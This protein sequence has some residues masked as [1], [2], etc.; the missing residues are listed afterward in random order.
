MI[1]ICCSIIILHCDLFRSSFCDHA[2]FPCNHTN[3]GVYSS[4]RFHTGTN[5]RS[6]CDHQRHCLTLHVGSH[7]RAVRIVV[8]Q[9]RNQCGSHGEHH[10]RR[11][12]HVI[13]HP[14]LIF[15]C[16]IQITSRYIFMN[17]MTFFIQRLIRLRY[18][19]IVFF[20]R[21]HV[22]Y[23]IR[24]SRILRITLVDPAIRSLYKTIFINSCI[25]CKRVDQTDVWS[26]RRLNRTHSSVMRIM[27]VSHLKSGT[28]TGQTA[29]S[30]CRQTS[31]MRQLTQRV[32]LI[33]KLRQLRRTK[34]F[35]HRSRHR[36]D[37][38]QR[39]RRN[40]LCILSCHSLS[41]N[42]FQSGHTDPILV[43][44]QFT[45]C[46]D[47]TIA[48]MVDIIIVTQTVFQM[49]I[50]VNGSKN[51]FLC[52]VLR[53]QLMDVTMDRCF[54]IVLIFIFFHQLCQSRIIY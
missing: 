25:R 19:V 36:F 17:K 39:L 37:I 31:L 18:M 48:Q 8:L 7:Q 16:F 32:I 1:N 14:S 46:T 30:Q 22:N 35:F 42:S 47:T 4:F 52:N 27:Y 6:F 13:K 9:E 26:L 15:L 2:C 10:L 49:H 50:I 29:R 45:N 20:V 23:F 38:D 40:T 34:E 28:I 21:S 12:V 3:T 54:Q 41:Y 51:I 33:H 43:L 5:Y 24:Y 44:Q 11:H 53:N